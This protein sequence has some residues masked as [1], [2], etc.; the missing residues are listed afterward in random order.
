MVKKEHFVSPATRGALGYWMYRRA[1]AVTAQRPTTPDRLSSRATSPS[2]ASHVGR[3]K[4]DTA[5]RLAVKGCSN[6]IDLPS[7][8]ICWPILTSESVSG[9]GTASSAA[10]RQASRLWWSRPMLADGCSMVARMPWY[11]PTPPGIRSTPR[12]RAAGQN[13]SSRPALSLFDSSSIR[14]SEHS[15]GLLIRGFGVQVPGGAPVLT[16]GFTAP[17]LFPCVRSV[18]M[19]AP[20]LLARTDPAIR[21]LSKAGHPAPDAEAFAAKPRRL[22]RP[23]P[24]RTHWTNGLDLPRWHREH[25]RSLYGDAVTLSATCW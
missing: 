23:A 24:P 14:I 6:C 17:G 20:C 11:V 10:D 16:W 8:R 15:S 5:A 3:A 22:V 13:G 2:L 21:G 12:T 9:N 1:A 7:R 19:F 18:P 25:T 4:R